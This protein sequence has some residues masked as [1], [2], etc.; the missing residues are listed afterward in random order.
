MR[1]VFYG[2][3]IF[4][5]LCLLTLGSYGTY[6]ISDMRLKMIDMEKQLEEQQSLQTDTVK[7]QICADTQCTIEEYDKNSG[8]LRQRTKVTS[9]N[10]LG[11][12]RQEL[13]DFLKKSQTPYYNYSLVAFSPQHVVI[14]QTRTSYETY[15]LTEEEGKVQVYK[16]DKETLYEPTEI[17]VDQL[18]ENLQKEIQT[19]K[20]LDSEEDLYNFLENYSS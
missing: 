2:I 20:Y 12:N 7:N 16:G 19:G 10:L 4:M 1:K 17:A 9:A 18:P 13:V 5:V 14:R 15:Y 11:M 6:K 8:E 3:G